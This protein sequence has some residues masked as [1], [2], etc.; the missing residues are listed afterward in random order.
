[1]DSVFLMGP[2][3]AASDPLDQPFGLLATHPR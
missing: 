1:M 2:A 3:D